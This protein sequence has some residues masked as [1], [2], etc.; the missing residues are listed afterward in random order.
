MYLCIY[1]P[2][3]MC[4]YMIYISHTYRERERRREGKKNEREWKSERITYIISC[5]FSLPLFSLSICLPITIQRDGD[6]PIKGRWKK[7][8]LL[9]K[10]NRKKEEIIWLKTGKC[11]LETGGRKVRIRWNRGG[12]SLHRLALIF[13]GKLG[14]IR[15]VRMEKGTGRKR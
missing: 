8:E 15:E 2:L 9:M 11:C 7:A 13:P 6:Q 14:H 1:I 10:W 3:Y 5:F 4:T 12:Y